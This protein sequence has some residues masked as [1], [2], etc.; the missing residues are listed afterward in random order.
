MATT[1]TS[2]LNDTIPTIIEEARFTEQFKEVLSKLVWRIT[3]KIHDGS[4]VNL[5]YFGTVTANVLTEGIDMVNPQAMEDT[6]V[7][8]TPAEVG[9]Q[10]LVTDKLARDDQ[11]DVIRAAGRILG[12]AMV[13]K[14]ESDLAG[15]LDDA[16]NSMGGADTTMTLGHLA[17]SWADLSGVTLANGGPAPKPYVAVQHPFVLLDLVDVFTPT[18]PNLTI[19]PLPGVGGGI[20]EEA[21]RNYLVGRVLG[22]NVFECGNIAIDSS[23]DAKGGVFAA[24]KGGGQVLV[25]AKEWDIK[26]DYDPSLR[27]TELNVVGEYAVG[28]YL[29]AWT[30]ELY[31]DASAPA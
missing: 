26:P 2:V 24:G 31:N 12:D 7:K 29:A 11:E 27:A 16:T 30:V 19:L 22:M 10:I 25:T 1:D 23:N 3:K 4:T 28:E 18:A 8:Y 6:S 9:A 13:V 21:L 15:Q 14:R 5:P 17:A 20:A